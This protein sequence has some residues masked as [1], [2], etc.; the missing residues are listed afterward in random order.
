M[1]KINNLL[2]KAK[3]TIRKTFSKTNADTEIQQAAREAFST[4]AGTPKT[5]INKSYGY[6]EFTPPPPS[7]ENPNISAGD[8]YQIHRNRN[9][10]NIENEKLRNYMR[11]KSDRN[12]NNFQERMKGAKTQE[13]RIE[14]AR[15]TLGGK[16]DANATEDQ[17]MTAAAKHYSSKSTMN[18]QFHDY[19]NANHMTQ[20][21]VGSG[22]VLSSMFALTG[23]KGHLSNPQL[24]GQ[25]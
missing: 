5:H 17:L 23:D 9:S 12:F 25:E 6:N 20:K 8:L 22:L 10:W 1:K 3:N 11:N 15:S 21:T 7:P 18:P 13:E 2:D 4:K 19:W 24:Y 14:I 16:I